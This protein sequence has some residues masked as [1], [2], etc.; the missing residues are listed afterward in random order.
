MQP[1]G[2][3]QGMQPG[4]HPN[5][6]TTRRTPPPHPSYPQADHGVQV[7]PT[8]YSPN[9]PEPHRNLPPPEH[10]NPGQPGPG[11][12]GASQGHQQNRPR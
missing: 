3:G 11:S 4:G 2:H 8:N 12:P 9:R 7:P 1:G 6:L 10:R 5:A